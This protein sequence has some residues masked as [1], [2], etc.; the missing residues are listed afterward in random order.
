MINYIDETESLLNYHIL[1]IVYL[2]ENLGFLKSKKT[3]S[4]LHPTQKVELLGFTISSTEMDHKLPGENIKL[5][6]ANTWLNQANTIF[7][8]S[9]APATFFFCTTNLQCL[10]EGGVYSVH[11]V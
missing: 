10:F 3:E 7:P 9:V 2:L 11:E 6:Q 4:E 5:K 8:R 1:A